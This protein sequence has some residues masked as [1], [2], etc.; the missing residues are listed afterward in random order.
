MNLK[1]F[2]NLIFQVSQLEHPL[3]CCNCDGNH[4]ANWRQ[5]PKFPGNKAPAPISNPAPTTARKNVSRQPRVLPSPVTQV[6]QSFSYADAIA[7][8]QRQN[9]P[10]L[11]QNSN[12]NLNQ[13]KS[14]QDEGATC[15]EIIKSLILLMNQGIAGPQLLQAFKNCLPQLRQAPSGVDQALETFLVPGDPTPLVP[16]YRVYR[17]D[18]ANI[19]ASRPG[20]GTCIYVKSNIE[21]HHFPLP[22]YQGV[23]ATAIEVK[24][25]NSPPLKIVSYYSQCSSGGVY[26]VLSA[27]HLSQILSIGANVIV[28]GDFN[29]R[30]S[31]WNV[32]N[33]NDSG[34][35]LHRFI[36]SRIELKLIAPTVPTKVDFYKNVYSTLDLA[37]FKNIPFNYNINVLNELSSDHFPVIIELET[38]ISN[39]KLPQQL[40]T[41]WEDFR[42]LLQTKPLPPLNLSNPTDADTAL[43]NVVDTMKEALRNSSRPKF[44]NNN[45]RLPKYIKDLVKSR[46]H[47]RKI[48]QRTR[49]P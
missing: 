24:L 40:L 1:V 13:E 46:N 18:R 31:Q 37:I 17:T 45:L 14:A 32:G 44:S 49:R 22:Y 41:N 12:V 27:S 42:Y 26:K 5:C 10:P 19:N 47:A 15:S 36:K 21:H 33:Q 9:F 20:G 30:H 48:W 16:N 7:N 29:A 11:T 3:R 34:R 23:D 2:F 38:D 43:S 4:A 28:A 6:N 39:L 8:K 25:K 35:I